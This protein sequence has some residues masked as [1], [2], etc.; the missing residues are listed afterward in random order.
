MMRRI[1]GAIG[2]TLAIAVLMVTAAAPA[3]ADGSRGIDVS[4]VLWNWSGAVFTEAPAN[5]GIIYHGDDAY[6]I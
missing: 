1:L 5:D 2:A 3:S 6:S 4:K